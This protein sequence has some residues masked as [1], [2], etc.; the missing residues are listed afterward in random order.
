MIL[1][2]R[3]LSAGKHPR[4]PMAA[5]APISYHGQRRRKG[6]IRRRNPGDPHGLPSPSELTSPV[7]I[8]ADPTSQSDIN[9]QI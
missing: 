3:G 7:G 6:G 4:R 9:P 1:I 5:E 2:G 8:T